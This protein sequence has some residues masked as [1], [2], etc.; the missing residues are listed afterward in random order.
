MVKNV[1]III[2]SLVFLVS[3]SPSE[4]QI[5]AAINQTEAARPTLTSTVTNTPEP[6]MTPTPEPT[7][8]LE[9]SYFED[10]SYV[11]VYELFLGAGV[12]CSER[13]INS[14]GTYTTEC[15]LILNNIIYRGEIS[16]NSEDTVSKFM[17]QIA[18][19]TGED[20]KEEMEE[21]F[22]DFVSFG[23]DIEE[24]QNWIIENLDNVLAASESQQVDMVFDDA[25]LYLFGSQGIGI[26]AVLARN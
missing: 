1:I 13:E 25:V 12:P 15:N 19:L 17:I 4:A 18:P 23:L 22:L 8:T 20:L 7:S 3:C 14:D 16:G 2:I 10:L 6:T 11:D 24:K 9:F 26:L 21:T 5:Q